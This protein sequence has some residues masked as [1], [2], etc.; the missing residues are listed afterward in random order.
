[1]LFSNE[2]E[3]RTEEQVLDSII[4]EEAQDLGLLDESG[5][6]IDQERL[7]TERKSLRT[8]VKKVRV[9][10]QQQLGKL[11]SR[12][13]LEMARRKNDPDWVK[14]RKYLDLAHQFRE[15]ISKKYQ[16]K[17]RTAARQALS[18][19]ET[20]GSKSSDLPKE[21]GNNKT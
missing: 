12:T 18:G 10:K 17:A 7:L 1:M 20:G 6:E 14:W 9:T 4:V 5:K 3:D 2:T 19:R 8:M 15:K 16:S 13:A 11:V 21:A